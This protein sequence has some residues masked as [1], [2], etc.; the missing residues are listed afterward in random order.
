VILFFSR[1]NLEALCHP[2]H[3]ARTARGE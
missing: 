3:T 2:H 1:S